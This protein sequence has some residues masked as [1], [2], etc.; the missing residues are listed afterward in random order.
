MQRSIL[1][2]RLLNLFLSDLFLFVKEADIV[3]CA[4]DNTLY[5]CSE[6]V[7]VILEKLEEVGK[8]LFEWFSNNFLKAN[9]DKRHLILST[10]KP[11]SINIDNEVIKNDNNKK[12]LRIN[13]NNRL[14]YDTHVTNICTRMSKTLHAL[15]RISQFMNIYKRRMTMKAF[16]AS[17]FGYCPLVWMFHSRKLNSRVNKLH[18][19]AL[20]IVY[21]DYA[22]SFTE[23]LEKDNSTTIHNRNIQLLATEL[24]KVKNG[25]SPPFMNEIFVENAQH[26]YD[27]RKKVEFKGNNVKAVYNGTETLTLLG[28]KIWEI[29]PDYIE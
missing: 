29:L 17:E 18:E 28:L 20:R 5:V 11:F 12:L 26:Y 23:L 22:S 15:A 25:L 1:G 10:D 8:I 14:G 7:D 24:F 13:L 19:R 3:S 6:K 4:D 27:F 21:Q 16:I 9:A 2:P